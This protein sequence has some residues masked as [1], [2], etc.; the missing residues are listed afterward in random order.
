[1]DKL[2]KTTPFMKTVDTINQII[3]VTNMNGSLLNSF[4]KSKPEYFVR[5]ITSSQITQS[6]IIEIKT[7]GLYKVTFNTIQ[8]KATLLVDSGKVEYYFRKD[9]T[10][11]DNVYADLL[12][13]SGDRLLIQGR[14]THSQTTMTIEL[15]DTIVE[16]FFNKTKEIEETKSTLAET[17]TLLEEYK[18]EK[19]ALEELVREYNRGVRALNQV[20]ADI[21]ALSNRISALE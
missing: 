16:A 3:D 7:T 2:T 14:S 11:D 18:A 12:L 21:I 6:Y 15:T 10:K 20:N 4:R 5:T 17:K 8:D 9:F 19:L 1:M 13:C